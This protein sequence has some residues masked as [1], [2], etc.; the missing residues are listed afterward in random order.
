MGDSDVGKT[1]IVKR[2]V[3]GTFPETKPDNPSKGMNTRK[4]ITVD[5]KQVT[6][7]IVDLAFDVEATASDFQGAKACIG[8]FD[9]SNPDTLQNVRNFIGMADRL[10]TDD[11]FYKCMCMNKCDEEQKVTEEE[12]NDMGNRCNSKKLY[13]VSAKSGDGIEDMF[14]EIARN[15]MGGDAPAG[16]KGDKKKKEKGE[17]KGGCTL[18]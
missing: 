12:A 1:C 4:E 15:V 8:V 10:V 14:Q 2:F 13:K 7:E 11:K 18:L 16:G 9:A 6:F 17:K 3:E 5:K